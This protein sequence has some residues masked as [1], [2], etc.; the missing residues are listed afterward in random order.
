MKLLLV[1]FFVCCYSASNAQQNLVNYFKK[2]NGPAKK[3]NAYYYRVL[4][5][6]ESKLDTIFIKEFYVNGN[7]PKLTA[8]TKK[9]QN[10]T[11]YYGNVY[12]YYENGNLASKEFYS[13]DGIAID[14]A[15]YYYPE[16]QLRDVW[17]YKS[18][19]EN[20][21]TKVKDSLYIKHF[22]TTGK[23]V[24][25]DG[26]GTATSY[27]DKDTE[28]GEYVNHK[29]NGLWKGTFNDKKYRFEE[30]YN[31]SKLVKG[32]TYDSLNN[33]TLYTQQEI[34]PEYPGGIRSL[35]QKVANTFKYSR[36]MMENNINGTVIISFVV[37]KDGK[38]D[39]IEIEKDL[40]YGS[41][42]AGVRVVENLRKWSPGIQRGIPVNVRY[43]LPI[44]LNI[45]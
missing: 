14:S 17:Y 12:C 42:E 11:T 29:K 40:G 2:D 38:V 25:K 43:R 20:D 26:N 28:S 6:P 5:I 36:E 21:K 24:L 8:K 18:V 31:A 23:L 44:R 9:I 37:K 35:M 19:Y 32:T 4:N 16:G 33:E 27:W 45:Q 15:F 39:N 34:A 22:D 7:K 41:G 30:Q 1:L 3:E 10:P 13:T